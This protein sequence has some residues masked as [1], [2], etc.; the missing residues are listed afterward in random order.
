MDTLRRIKKLPSYSEE[1]SDTDVRSDSRPRDF[2]RQRAP[3]HHNTTGNSSNRSSAIADGALG[4]V[5]TE[6]EQS[7][8]DASAFTGWSSRRSNSGTFASREPGKIRQNGVF[9]AI[10]LTAKKPRGRPKKSSSTKAKAIN[11]RENVGVGR[12]SMSR[13][14]AE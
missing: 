10:E 12:V 7:T 6:N 8:N 11:S 1:I 13:S 4:V 2:L 9:P 5:F 3:S 14:E